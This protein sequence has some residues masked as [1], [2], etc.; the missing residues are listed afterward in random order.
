MLSLSKHDNVLN[1]FNI[2]KSIFLNRKDALFYN[3]KSWSKP[4]AAYKSQTVLR[5]WRMARRTFS[6][7]APAK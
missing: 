3:H 7:K 4:Q 1:S 5:C 2:K 6:Q